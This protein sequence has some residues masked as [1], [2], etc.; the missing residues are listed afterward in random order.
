MTEIQKKIA[1][2]SDEIQDGLHNV[3]N[4]A[5]EQSPKSKAEYQD[6]VTAFLII[7]IAALEIALEER[8]SVCPVCKCIAGT[9][10][11]HSWHYNKVC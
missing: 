10:C 5:Q 3:I 7:R 1:D 11:A 6:Y 9:S 2:R 4:Q 8:K